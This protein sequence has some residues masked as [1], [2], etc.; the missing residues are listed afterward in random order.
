MFLFK[1]RL[2]KKLVRAFIFPSVLFVPAVAFAVP[3]TVTATVNVRSGPGVNYGR[4]AA[5]PVGLRVDAGPCR[6]RWCQ[7]NSGGYRGWVSARFISF[8]GYVRG[9]VYPN[10]AYLNPVDPY[11]AYPSG[12]YPSGSSTTVI[13]GGGGWG[14]GYGWDRGWT[15]GWPPYWGWRG[16]HGA[17]PGWR[18]GWG[19]RYDPYAGSHRGW[20]PAWGVGPAR[21][22]HWSGRTAPYRI[23][24]G[25]RPQFGNMR[26]YHSGR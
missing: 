16:G 12:Y 8:G 9:P 13:I 11:S 26:P 19:P 22:P 3:A 4:L 7:V 6:G 18:H 1:K 21:G 10:R 14:P 15:S 5:L 25:V 17:Y 23:G 24:T 2:N 20:N